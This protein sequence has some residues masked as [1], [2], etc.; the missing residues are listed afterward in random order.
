MFLLSLRKKLPPFCGHEAEPVT[1][2]EGWA[3]FTTLTIH[4]GALVI[5]RLGVFSIFR[6]DILGWSRGGEPCGSIGVI[7]V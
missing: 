3:G 5:A 6:A 7:C 4:D 1:W 2:A